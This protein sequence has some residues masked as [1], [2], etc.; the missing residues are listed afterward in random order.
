MSIDYYIIIKNYIKWK[1]FVCLN[2]QYNIEIKIIQF[3]NMSKDKY[4][5][6]LLG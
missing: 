1:L 3:G 6:N 5:I 2:A 4:L